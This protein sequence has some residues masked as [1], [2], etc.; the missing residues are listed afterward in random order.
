MNEPRKTSIS[1]TVSFGNL[2]RM[3]WHIG[4]FLPHG[5]YLVAGLDPFM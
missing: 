1:I 2:L 4:C 5:P 3:P